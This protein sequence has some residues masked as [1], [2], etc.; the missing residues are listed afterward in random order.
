MKQ[1]ALLAAIGIFVASANAWAQ[2]GV[3]GY[4]IITCEVSALPLDEG[5]PI[6]L[7]KGKGVTIAPDTPMHMSHLECV[8]TMEF[9]ADKSFKA[10]GYCTHTDR[11]GDKWID[12]NWWDPT[13]KK[14]RYETTGISGKYKDSHVTGSF[15]YTDLS[16]QSGCSGVSNWVND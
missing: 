14:G 8:T 7:W 10:N 3:N 16:S 9:M 11:D 15:V 12:R 5:H 1:K 2:Q 4:N 13:I 6:V